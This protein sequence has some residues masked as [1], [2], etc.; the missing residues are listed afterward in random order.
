MAIGVATDRYG[1]VNKVCGRAI[2]HGMLVLVAWE[3]VISDEFR[4]LSGES[5]RRP[6]RTLEVAGQ[7]GGDRVIVFLFRAYFVREDE[8][9]TLSS[10]FF[11]IIICYIHLLAL[12]MVQ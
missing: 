12:H 9:S 4:G 6:H 7:E 3:L 5:C 2:D 11:A 10:S 1:E 8:V